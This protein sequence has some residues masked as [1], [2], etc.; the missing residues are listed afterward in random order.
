MPEA[1]QSQP[2]VS[3]SAQ[4]GKKGEFLPAFVALALIHQDDHGKA[5]ERKS[6]LTSLHSK[7]RSSSSLLTHSARGGRTK[8]KR[9]KLID[10]LDGFST[11]P[12]L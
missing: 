10:S 2:P 4:V 9:I 6:A 7:I 1:G 5:E 11:N 3:L 12:P 8:L